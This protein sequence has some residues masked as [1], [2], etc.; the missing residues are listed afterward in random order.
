ML[1]HPSDCLALFLTRLMYVRV[2]V[3]VNVV[4]AAVMIDDVVVLVV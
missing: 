3:I 2:C 4:V 1:R